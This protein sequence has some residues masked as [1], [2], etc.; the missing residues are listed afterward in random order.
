MM[1]DVVVEIPMPLIIE[2]SEKYKKNGCARKQAVF[3][4]FPYGEW[5][6]HWCCMT[7]RGVGS[8]NG[9]GVGHS[10]SE[11]CDLRI[12]IRGSCQKANET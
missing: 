2:A 1:M 5:R 8:D 10:C 3:E 7:N 4:L 12:P 6:Y 11:E 9:Y